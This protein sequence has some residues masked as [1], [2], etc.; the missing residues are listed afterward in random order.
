M[1]GFGY[2]RAPPVLVSI[3][4]LFS[5]TTRLDNALLTL[6]FS[7]GKSRCHIIADRRLGEKIKQIEQIR[8][9]DRHHRQINIISDW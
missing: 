8:W 1:I 6:R 3:F 7:L 4:H 2:A 5:D 9:M